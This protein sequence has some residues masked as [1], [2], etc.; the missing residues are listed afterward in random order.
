MRHERDRKV[1]NIDRSYADAIYHGRKRHRERHIRIYT[2]VI[3]VPRRSPV[4]AAR[5]FDR[6]L[7]RK[8]R[9]LRKMR[10]G[11]A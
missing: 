1:A 2:D 5:C 11:W 3:S 4:Q 7:R 9:H 10:R 6:V 8:A